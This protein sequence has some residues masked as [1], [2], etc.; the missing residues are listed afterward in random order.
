MDQVTE[1]CTTRKKHKGLST[2][3]NTT[4]GSLVFQIP[5]AIGRACTYCRY[6]W[7]FR[8]LLLK[9]S[10]CDQGYSALNFGLWKACI[11]KK[12]FR[13]NQLVVFSY[14]KTKL[15]INLCVINQKIFLF[16][17]TNFK[18]ITSTV[19]CDFF[20]FRSW[21]FPVPKSV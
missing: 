4:T 9:N 1:I 3:H 11:K 12:S 20:Y 13:I 5:T 21:F 6:F 2:Q 19:Y 17:Q 10:E 16:L 8:D 7:R 14:S 15:D 18:Y